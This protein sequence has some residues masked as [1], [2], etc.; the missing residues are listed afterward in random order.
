MTKDDRDDDSYLWDGTGEPDAAVV[1]LEQALAPLRHRALPP[2]LP[3]R[4]RGLG[5]RAIGWAGPAAAAAAVLLVVAAGWFVFGLERGGWAVQT[6]AGSPVVDGVKLSD[7][8][9]SAAARLGVG[10]WLVTDGASRARI[11]VAEIGR[12]DVEPNSRVQLVE[13]RGRE[14][15]MALARGTIHAQIW[16]PPKFFFVNT[17]SAVA[18]DLGCAYTLQVDDRGEGL[19]RVTHGWVEFESDGRESFVPEGAMCV[20]RPGV[21]PGTPRYED[22][23]SGYGEA[24]EILDFGRADD[25]RRPAAFD[26][27]I[28]QARRR[29]ALTLWHLLSRGTPAERARVYD[30]LSAMA[31]PPTG[32]SREMILSGDR[33]ALDRWWDALGLEVSSWWKLLKKKW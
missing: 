11:A 16:A 2:P 30:R 1:R 5:A 13:S 28:T 23:P 29:D 3:A 21:G 22:A 27:V 20:T 14:Q 10:E 18:I 4:R 6:I 15:R 7:G 26:L 33:L 31:P 12:V 9:S 17:P 25:L 8:R 32:V 24:L 19:V